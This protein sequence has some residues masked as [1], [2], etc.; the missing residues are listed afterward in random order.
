MYGSCV[1]VVAGLA[2]GPAGRRSPRQWRAGAPW[3]VRRGDD[4]AGDRAAVQ[5]RRAASLVPWVPFRRQRPRHK[6]GRRI[7]YLRPCPRTYAEICPAA[8]RCTRQGRTF[9]ALCATCRRPP[10]QT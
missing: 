1:K 7:R 8:P 3:G 4:L 5:R 9:R 6:S 10:V 2:G